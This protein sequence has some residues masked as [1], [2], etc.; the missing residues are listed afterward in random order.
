MEGQTTR[1][2]TE[3]AANANAYQ[4]T[5]AGLAMPIKVHVVFN[6]VALAAVLVLGHP[7]V[8]GLSFLASCAVDTLYQRLI[9]HRLARSAQ[10]DVARGFRQ[11]SLLCVARVST[12]LTGP[13]L[14]AVWGGQTEL[15]YLAIAVASM[16][17]IACASGSLSRTVFWS[18]AG[19]AI[20][21]LTGAL[22]AIFPAPALAGLMISMACLIVLLFMISDGTTRAVTS[23]Q[24]AYASNLA[25]IPELE[26]ARDH[27]MAETR[28][29]DEAREVARQANGAKSNFL[30]TMSHE[31][32]TPMNGVLG[33][34][35]LLRREE[36]DPVQAGRL[37]TL[38]ESGEHLLSILNDIL[39]MSKVSAGRLDISPA[40][41]NLP[42]FLERAVAFWRARA[43][44][45]GVALRLEADENL[46]SHVWMDAIRVRQVLF[47]LIGNALKFTDDGAVTVRV[48][49]QPIGET[50]ARIHM[51]IIDTGP[52]IPQEHLPALFERFSQVD[53][54]EERRFGGTGLGLA[55]AS[56]LTELMGGRVWVESQLGK[57]SIFHVE[58][59]FDLA[60]APT[61]ATTEIAPEDA[62][63]GDLD[64]LIVDDNPVNLLV[65]QQILCAFGHRVEKAT[66]GQDALDLLASRPF[67]LTLMDIQMPG[68]TGVQALQRLRA[69]P[70][71]NQAVP[72]IALTADV[73]SGGRAHYL[74]LGFTEH[75]AKPIQIPV[76]MSAI[77][78][79][80]AEPG[81]ERA[82]FNVN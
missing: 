63:V 57:G 33:M 59:I 67:D 30:A 8:A 58:A 1:V 16:V 70:G 35:Q 49:A 29:A 36:K 42:L 80:M 69:S 4:L 51:A 11:L 37:A 31:I 60:Q 5:L 39:D 24:E 41:E 7:M 45:K 6:A 77:S 18:F 26:A 55:I 34:A 48:A 21:A 44:E 53:E 13:T 61:A 78:R 75:A 47:N 20:L 52:G 54:S 40:P 15:A 68:M 46:P 66:S 62:L 10:T 22:L 14:L 12:Y 23:W 82:I 79:A 2:A 25:M 74:E 50:A 19:P 73:T 81:V 72:V 32:R 28:A 64:V 65:L 38:I 3:P 27:A 9:A 56:Q 17:A 76:L 43:D 71:P